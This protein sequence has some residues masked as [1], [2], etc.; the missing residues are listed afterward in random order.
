MQP[1]QFEIQREV[2]ALRDLRRRSTNP[3]ALSID[4]DLPTQPSPPSPSTAYWA[5]NTDSEASSSSSH[6]GRSTTESSATSLSG[7]NIGGKTGED[8]A[9]DPFHLFWVPASVH[10][11]IAPAEF[12]AFLQEH[13]RSPPTNEDATV[14]RSSSISSPLGRKRSMLSRQYRPS[15]DDGVDQE[16]EQKIVPL[17]RNRTSIHT[18]PGPQL[19]IDDLQKLERLAEKASKNDDPSELR[20]MLRRSLSLNISPTGALH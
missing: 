10:P 1:S 2:E 9:D 5:A 16:G 17:R 7:N 8:T 13:A 18:N 11:E 12:R 15:E 20:T 19:T 14:S 6:D 4:P 3:G